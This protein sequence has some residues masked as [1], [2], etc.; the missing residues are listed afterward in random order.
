MDISAV[1]VDQSISL[2]NVEVVAITPDATA[3]LSG[4]LINAGSTAKAWDCPYASSQPALCIKFKRLADD[5][6][7]TWPATVPAYSATLFYAQEPTLLDSDGDGIADIDDQCP[8]TLKGTPVN[9]A[10]CPLTLR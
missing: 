8:A 2:A 7:L 5:S 10:G 6:S 1:P 9:A 4:A 3:A